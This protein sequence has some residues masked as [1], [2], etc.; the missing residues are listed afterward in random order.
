MKKRDLAFG[1]S[2]AAAGLLFA[3]CAASAASLAWNDLLP[4]GTGTAA[5]DFW[6]VSGHAPVT[7]SIAEAVCTGSGILDT[8][9]FS[10]AWS[11]ALPSFRTLPLK[12][13]I[14]YIR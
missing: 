10:R 8:R 11:N 5:N 4:Y 1:R 12:G 6:D 2:S 7:I 3:A 14:L 13:A 9:T